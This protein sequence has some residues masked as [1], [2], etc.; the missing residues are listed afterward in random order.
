MIRDH[1]QL[2]GQLRAL[3]DHMQRTVVEHSERSTIEALATIVDDE[4]AGD[5]TFAIDRVS[6]TALIAFFEREVAPGR[7]LVLIAEGLQDSGD[8][9]GQIVLPRGTPV[10][11]AEVR[12]LVDPIDGTRGLMYQKRSAWILTGVAPNRGPAT[13]LRDI[14]LAV[15]TE[16]PLV[17]QHLADQLWAIRGAGFHAERRNR[18]SGARTPL[19]LRPSTASSVEQGFATFARFFPGPR[20]DLAAIDDDVMR[21]AVGPITPGRAQSFEDQYICTGGQLYE[22]IAGH[23]RF[24][25]DLRPL[26]EPL[27]AQRGFASGI[28]CHPYDLASV[29]IAE[30]AGVSITDG[31]GHPLDA[32]LDVSTNVAWAGFANAAIRQQ[33]E[34]PLLAALRARGLL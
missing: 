14:E 5:T 27:L 10:E 34:P 15:Q 9:A 22:L 4:Q 20:T 24:T 29:L 30:E 26:V 16:I 33:I 19:R 8:G 2:L 17:K 1:D 21:A 6:E 11:A 3:H 12:I 23:D 32:P 25:A 18:L 28:A 13:G 31:R 7:P